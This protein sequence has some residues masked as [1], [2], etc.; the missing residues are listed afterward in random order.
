MKEY[1]VKSIFTIP[2][3]SSIHYENNCLHSMWCVY[4]GNGKTYRFYCNFCSMI[5]TVKFP[6]HSRV[7]RRVY[8]AEDIVGLHW[9]CP[10]CCKSTPNLELM[11]DE[12]WNWG[13]EE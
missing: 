6:R 3:D 2:D 4:Q 10:S 13:E 9:V 7:V 5:I 12:K 11:E 8:E 1:K